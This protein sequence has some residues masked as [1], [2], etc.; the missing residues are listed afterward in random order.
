MLSPHLSG[1]PGESVFS[2]SSEDTR[3]FIEACLSPTALYNILFNTQV[4]LL[5]R[6]LYSILFS[7]PVLKF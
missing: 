3:V 5:Y 1:P 6:F 7:S 2:L 4:S